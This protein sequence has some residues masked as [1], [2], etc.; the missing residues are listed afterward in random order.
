MFFEYKTNYCNDMLRIAVTNKSNQIQQTTAVNSK[1][2]TK[3]IDSMSNPIWLYSH[4]RRMWLLMRTS[5]ES[6]PAR[7]IIQFCRYILLR[8]K[9]LALT[10]NQ[11]GIVTKTIK[12][13]LLH[14]LKYDT[15]GWSFGSWSSIDAAYTLHK[16]DWLKI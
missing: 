2:K 13:N 7:R 14:L 5:R 16:K 10:Q 9:H 8:V 6:N 3:K 4:K 12:Q 1:Q 15:Y 11:S